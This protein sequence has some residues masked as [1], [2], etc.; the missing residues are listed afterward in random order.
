MIPIDY[1]RGLSVR[2]VASVIDGWTESVRRIDLS[3]LDS[4]MSGRISP[5][6]LTCRWTLVTIFMRRSKVKIKV[7]DGRTAK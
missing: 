6:S 3:T 7:R 5:I 2:C 4:H 1:F